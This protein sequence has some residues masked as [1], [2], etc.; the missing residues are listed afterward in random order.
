M[1]LLFVMN[2]TKTLKR[3]PFAL[4]ITAILA[5][6]GSSNTLTS[7]NLSASDIVNINKQQSITL[8]AD[9]SST[10]SKTLQS[11]SIQ[12]Q[13][14]SIDNDVINSLQAN[15]SYFAASGRLCRHTLLESN[16]QNYNYVACQ[17]NTEQWVL[18][19]SIQQNL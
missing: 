4:F 3:V 9:V 10:F 12:P 14:L 2:M 15:E 19:N 5:G 11:I 1:D 8:P 18:T 17:L 13:S 16:T 6:C 7:S